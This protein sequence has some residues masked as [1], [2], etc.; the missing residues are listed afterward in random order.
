ML[1]FVVCLLLGNA[2]IG[3]GMAYV[4]KL[5]QRVLPS[6]QTNAV[7]GKSGIKAVA[8]AP[9]LCQFNLGIVGEFQ[10]VRQVELSS[11]AATSRQTP[12]KDLASSRLRA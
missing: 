12:R 10:L 3:L 2:L 4:I 7:T 8:C 6:R 1:I 9:H 11:M 5:K